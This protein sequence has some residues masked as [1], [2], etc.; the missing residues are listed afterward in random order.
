MSLAD[1]VRSGMLKEVLAR[2]EQQGTV[3]VMARVTL[4]RAIE[5]AWV[6]QVFEDH[7]QRQYPRELLFS[8]VVELVTL[9]SLGL[10]PSLH[11]AAKKAA[12]LPVSL[13]ALYEKINRTEPAIMRALVSGSAKRLAPVID[14]MAP[15]ASLPGWQLR[16][17]D[18]NHLPGTDKR[19]GP[20]RGQRG[21]ALPGYTLVVYDPDTTLVT[22]IVPCEDAHASERSEAAALVASACAGELWIGDRNFCTLALMQGWQDAQA[23]FIVR[24]HAKH[25]R[26]VHE[27]RWVACGSVETG[28][29]REQAI[30]LGEGMA[31]WRRIELQLATPTEEGDTTIRLW[32]NLPA[33]VSAQR[34]AQLYRKRWKVEGMFQRLEAVLHSEIQ[35]FGHPR[36]ALL[37]FAVAVL[38]YNVLSVLKRGIEHAHRDTVPEL[39]VSTYYLASEISTGYQGML[40]A[41]PPEHWKSWTGARPLAIA[42]RLLELARHVDPKHVS[43][44]KRGPKQRT[45]TPYV[46]RATVCAHVSTTRVLKQSRVHRP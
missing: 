45:S 11:A 19:L 35:S 30:E 4:E 3:S 9:V 44:H 12:Q 26:V 28:R 2:F 27:G 15:E 31:S 25:P 14:A 39:D 24:E 6:D 37:G 20:L 34:I 42:R 18:G 1:A 32:S 5:P 21:A 10:R 13:A 43:T 41:L 8:T 17:L 40:I 22:D 7:R 16:V 46:D 38:A 33:Q 36:A 23:S 29:V